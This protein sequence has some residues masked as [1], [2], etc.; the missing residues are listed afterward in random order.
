MNITLTATVVSFAALLFGLPL[1]LGV[2][3]LLGAY[4]IVN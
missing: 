2:A 3:R 1:V 4:D